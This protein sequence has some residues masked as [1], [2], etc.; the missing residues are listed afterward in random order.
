[1]RDLE[2]RGAGNIL[3]PEQSGHLAAVGYDLYCRLLE[4]SVRGLKNQPPPERIEVALSLGVDAF[5]PGS[6][7]P[8]PSQRIEVYRQLR[9][10]MAED[11]RAALRETLRDRF[12]P[13]PDEA[14]NLLAERRLAQL[15]HRAGVAAVQLVDLAARGVSP[16]RR[17]FPITLRARDMERVKAALDATDRAFRQV[18]D[19]TLILKVGAA[20]SRDRISGVFL[21]SFL[22]RIF[23]SA[24]KA[25]RT[26]SGTPT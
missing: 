5:L 2:I 25:A 23:E 6:Y 21:L 26:T 24:L 10:G 19:D 13:L 20:P 22:T 8:D 11:D 17:A 12:G 1:M 4:A 7:V 15:A 14:E 18:D 16:S 3:G 9:R